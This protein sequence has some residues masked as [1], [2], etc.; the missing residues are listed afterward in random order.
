MSIKFIL[1]MLGIIGLFIGMLGFAFLFFSAYLE[2]SHEMLIT[3]DMFGE[4]RV[5]A[6]LTAIS[7]PL[8]IYVFAD[9]T[10]KIVAED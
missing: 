3:L 9:Y 7:L 1:K 8:G 6:I 10:N 4:A 5:E 2:P